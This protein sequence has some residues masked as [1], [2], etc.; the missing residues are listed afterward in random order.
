MYLP[1]SAT[2]LSENSVL[3]VRVLLA[4]GPGGDLQTGCEAPCWSP[5]PTA[6]RED[7]E[8]VS[9]PSVLSCPNPPGTRGMLH[10]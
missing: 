8:S 10:L 7:G 6:Q 3:C 1:V 5:S 2:G 9:E 4:A